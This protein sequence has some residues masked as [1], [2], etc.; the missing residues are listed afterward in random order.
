[1]SRTRHKLVA[2]NY[3]DNVYHPVYDDRDEQVLHV[4]A[5]E[6]HSRRRAERA[7]QIQAAVQEEARYLEEEEARRVEELER[8]EIE[9]TELIEAGLK[10]SYN[11][12]KWDR[13]S[14]LRRP[15]TDGRPTP[16]WKRDRMAEGGGI[17]TF[18]QLD[19]AAP[20]NTGTEGER[21]AALESIKVVGDDYEDFEDVW[22]E[23]RSLQ[24]LLWARYSHYEHNSRRDKWATPESYLAQ[25]QDVYKRLK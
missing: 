8:Q 4:R 1:M 9:Y 10:D 18:Q 11:R 17:H 3:Y 23:I 2:W 13:E 19:N 5:Q 12:R 14:G 24:R 16:R 20:S 6:V 22:I 7:Q 21:R 25:L 15:N